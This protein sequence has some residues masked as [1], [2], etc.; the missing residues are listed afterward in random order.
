AVPD[1]RHDDVEER[2]VTRP[3]DAVGE[4]VRVGAAALARDRVDGFHVVRAHFVEPLV[5]QRDDLVLARARLERLEDVL[6][7]AIHHRRRHVEQ[8]QLVLALEH[9]RLEHHLLAVS[10]FDAELLQREEERRLDEVDAERHAGHAFGTQDVSDLFGGA[11][12]EPGF[13]GH[14]AAHT[15]HARERLT[16]G[17]LR[18]VEAMMARGR[19][20]VPHPRLA[21]APQQTT[22]RELVARPFAD[23]GAREI[24]DV[25]L[26]EHEH[27]PE[28]RRRQRLT[29]AAETIR[30][31]P[32]EVDTLLEVD[33]HVTRRLKRAIPA[34]ARI[35]IGGSDGTGDRAGLARHGGSSVAR[36]LYRTAN[37]EDGRR[38]R[39]SAR[40]RRRGSTGTAEIRDA[41]WAEAPRAVR[42]ES[43]CPGEYGVA[44]AGRPAAAARRTRT[45]RDGRRASANAGG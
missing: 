17:D 8:R 15:D 23:D 28:P 44:S 10:D 36:L 3:D 38:R 45:P 25:V 21:V 24:A 4:V 7:D 1:E 13:R 20:E 33:L 2:L 35:D 32:P 16:L 18:R 11:L 9:P 40:G 22:A 30:V 29:R 43:A 37:F 12:E 5:G 26:I 41:R 27:G 39:V 19:A 34:V 14:R 6:V 42:R 31:Q